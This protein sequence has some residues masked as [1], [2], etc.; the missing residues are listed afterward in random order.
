MGQLVISFC[1]GWLQLQ[2]SVMIG[3]A[4]TVNA[5]PMQTVGESCLLRLRTNF[6]YL[7]ADQVD[8]ASQR[9]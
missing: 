1:N 8:T 3:V 6:T 9:S 2:D 7:K 5:V 4:A